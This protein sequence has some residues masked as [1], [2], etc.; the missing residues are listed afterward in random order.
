MKTILTTTL[1]V[2]A[3][4]TGF[5]QTDSTAPYFINKNM[6]A[7]SLLS[8]KDSSLITEKNIVTGK[9]VI[10]MLFNPE[11][12]HCHRQYKLLVSIPQVA[13]AQLIMCSTE[14]FA[15]IAAFAQKFQVNKYPFI[16][17]GKDYKIVLGPFFRPKTIP[18]LAVYNKL[19]KFVFIKQG[20]ASKK[21]IVAALK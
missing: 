5:A 21:E 11:C 12:E 17:L 4:A 10:F 14:D 3:L 19:G 16:Q 6:P 2:F 13:A 18:V 9:P 8:V 7:F 15:K 1:F 20:E